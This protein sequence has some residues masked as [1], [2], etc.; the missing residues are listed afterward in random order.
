[1]TLCCCLLYLVLV[2][3][4]EYEARGEIEAVPL[5]TEAYL[6]AQTVVLL[7]LEL[8]GRAHTAVGS[9]GHGAPLERLEQRLEY[10]RVHARL[11]VVEVHL[12]RGQQV[13]M[14]RVEDALEAH[15]H[16]V[17]DGVLG[18]ELRLDVVLAHLEHDL[19]ADFAPSRRVEHHLLVCNAILNDIVINQ[20]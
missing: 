3:V 6:T 19:L 8:L 1:M 20:V 4:G 18:L 7:V 16:R 2:L 11:L 13:M 14:T 5:E 10:G 9:D 15:E 17:D 12:E